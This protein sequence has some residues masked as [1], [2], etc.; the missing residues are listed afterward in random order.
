VHSTQHQFKLSALRRKNEL[1]CR[2]DLWGFV[3]LMVVIFFVLWV[4]KAAYTDL[5]VHVP[6]DLVVA[7]HST[8]LPNALREDCLRVT[9]SRDGSVYFRDS[10]ISLRDLSNLFQEGM[11]HGAEKKAYVSADARAKYGDVG[12]VLEQIRLAG[13]E[14]IAFLT[15]S[16]QL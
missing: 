10:R 8:R 12:A 7:H 11:R 6:A 9:I 13:I 15:T 16:L 1:L 3:S 4:E 14:N 5:P 2:I